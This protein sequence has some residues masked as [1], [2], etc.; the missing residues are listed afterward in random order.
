MSCRQPAAT[1]SKASAPKATKAPA[2][3]Q[4]SGSACFFERCTLTLSAE[5]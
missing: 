5:R 4:R 1:V 3:P 2:A